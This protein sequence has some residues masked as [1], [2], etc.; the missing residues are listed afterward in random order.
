MDAL[1]R[2]GFDRNYWAMALEGSSFMGGIAVISTGGAVALFINAMTGSKTLIGLAVTVQSLF[3]IVGQ[4][5]SAPYVR[6]IRRL[7]EFLF[8]SMAIQRVAPL[9]MSLPLLLGFA[10][11]WSVGIFLILFGFFWFMDG[12]LTIAWAELCTRALKPELRGHMMG[13]QVTIGGAASLL[14]GLLLTWLLATPALSNNHRFAMVFILAGIVLLSSLFFIRLVRDPNP[15]VNPEKLDV[16]QYY[17]RI[18]SVI[19]R[20]KPL[21]HMLA[22]RIPSYIGFASVSFIV[23]YGA[24]VL[25]LSETQ[26]SWLI[27]AN[28]VGGLIGGISLGE[29]SRRFGNKTIILIC[30]TG[31][32]IALGM[33][34]LLTFLPVLGYAWL[35][36]T[37]TLASLTANNWLGYFSYIL[38]I[39]PSEERSVY[40]VISNFVGIPFSFSGYVMGAVIDRFGFIAMFVISGIFAAA[41][42]VLSIRLLSKRQIQDDMSLVNGC[43]I[44]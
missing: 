40:Q 34:V 11:N 24:G 33:A 16:R 1:S 43:P 4:L 23:V 15:I 21:Q 5:C 26:V 13:M 41:A 38:D 30:N 19:R 18:P 44:E 35:F 14:T 12:F 27:Y 7:P 3:V 10:G 2:K 42:I 20:S 29:I 39:A 6:S 17:M 22:A 25:S 31:V 8:N 37:C 32:Y 28:I 9:L 36:A